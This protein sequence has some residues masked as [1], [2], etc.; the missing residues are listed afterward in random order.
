MYNK[1]QV[2]NRYVPVFL[3]CFGSTATASKMRQTK[4]AQNKK[5]GF[6]LRESEGEKNPL[7]NFSVNP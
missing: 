3:P 2:L 4:T 7:M 5:V 6:F 1:A